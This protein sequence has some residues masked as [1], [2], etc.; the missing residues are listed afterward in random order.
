MKVGDVGRLAA[1]A[2]FAATAAAAQE[3]PLL[4]VLP[5]A[6]QARRL[7]LRADLRM[8]QKRYLEAIDLYQEALVLAPQNAVLLNKTGIAFHQLLRLDDAK[9]YYER[10]TRADK[11]YAHAW[12][13]LGTIYYGKKDYGK[14]IRNYQRA[15]KVAP[16]QGAIHSNL[17]TAYFARK[18]YEQ[19]M[20]EYR[21]ALLLDPEVFEHRSLFGVLMQDHS[22]E[23]RARFHFLL[24]KGFAS[25]GYVDKCLL[26]LRRALEDGFPP[27]QAQGDAAFVLVRDDPRFQ[28][29]FAQRIPVVP[30]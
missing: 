17:G 16:A 8:I 25:L 27:A 19:A 21:L 4:T 6:E 18:Q 2:L 7:E 29:L 5:R 24:A 28:E 20:A 14:A 22:V 1:V 15:L 11:N 3:A 10:S 9:K 12:N 30:R 13:N 23:D 26:Y